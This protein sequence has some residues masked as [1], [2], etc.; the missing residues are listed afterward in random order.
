VT[1]VTTAAARPGG[2]QAVDQ[3]LRGPLGDLEV[4]AR[5][6]APGPTWVRTVDVLVVGSGIAGLALAVRLAAAGLR[7]DLVTKAD[8]PEGSTRWAQGG[9]ATADQPDDDPA[10]HARDT[11]VAGAGLGDAAAV[12]VL[13]RE[14]PSA[15]DELVA[16]G[17]RLDPVGGGDP[18]P[19]RTL[20]G[21]HSRARIVHA[22]GDATGAEVVRALTAA[23]RRED[24]VT[25]HEHTMLL[26]LVPSSDGGVGGARLARLGRRSQLRDVGRVLA[27]AVVLATGGWGQVFATT[28]N[29]DV[30]TGDG[31]AAALR[32]G[33][34]VRDLEFVQF[35]PTVLHLPSTP[36][37]RRAG[38]SAASTMLLTEA[39]RGEGAFV[40]DAR[41]A[42]VLDGVHP[43]AD[44]A[45][46]DVVAAA[47]ARAMAATDTDH[48]YLDARRLGADTLLS[49]FPTVV[50]ACRGLGLDPAT[51]VLP[52]A[53]AA[54]YAC[55]G[56]VADMSGRT[57]LPGLFA[58]G[59]VASTGV[60]GANRL[61]SNSLL[62]GLVVA[63][64][65]AALLAGGLPPTAPVPADD[66]AARGVLVDPGVRP[67][68]A[69]AAERDA[70]V[71]RDPDAM[72]ALLT[73]LRTGRADP[74]AAPPGRAAWEATNLHTITVATVAAA[75]ARRESRGCHR[76]T[77][78]DGPRDT[79]RRHLTV[80][81][82]GSGAEGRNPARIRLALEVQP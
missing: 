51:Q 62:E 37:G 45:P 61:A 9:I 11:L 5:L 8:L 4:P 58:L 17:V 53:P 72:S 27:R 3:E 75:L 35:H 46:R 20:E 82:A 65:L 57:T 73:R 60:H 1:T 59:E 42:H 56:V 21:G 18:A 7:V 69:R 52:V 32:A 6:A 49:R 81:S 74:V 29:P 54:H 34:D 28:T 68:L 2:R 50:A 48:L 10:L 26:D 33:A 43:L 40:V 31:L 63:R 19:A 70:G 16:A 13:V 22:G 44:L 41:G 12:D 36:R 79:W 14:G 30:A 80:R 76:R 77:D 55:G 67:G 47:M 23:V 78:V 25:V 15:V 39:L 66:G 38:R 71:L 24:R 64:R